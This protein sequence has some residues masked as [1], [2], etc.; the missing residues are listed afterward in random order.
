MICGST[1]KSGSDLNERACEL[2]V[3]SLS[4]PRAWTF[5]TTLNG[6]SVSYSG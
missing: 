2:R 1:L 3:S 4:E 5:V 6:S